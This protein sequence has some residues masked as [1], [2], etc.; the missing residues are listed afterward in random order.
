M[1]WKQSK[2]L[3]YRDTSKDLNIEVIPYC[4]LTPAI[5][6]LRNTT[7]C[8]WALCI[9][10]LV[11]WEMMQVMISHLAALSVEGTEVL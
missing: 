5:L 4:T 3:F 1:Q 7:E 9:L 11:H 6:N 2:W 10:E 8:W